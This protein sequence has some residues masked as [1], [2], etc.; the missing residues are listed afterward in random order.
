MRYRRCLRFFCFLVLEPA[1]LFCW[2]GDVK[3]S[4]EIAARVL[5]QNVSND[6]CWV[7]PRARHILAEIHLQSKCQISTMSINTVR[8]PFLVCTTF[9]FVF[10]KVCKGRSQR[11]QKHWSRKQARFV[12]KSTVRDEK[13]KSSKRYVLNNK[14][15][16]FVA[17]NFVPCME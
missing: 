9:N 15:T 16:F 14:S 8:A 2:V 5:F 13:W 11:T 12:T 7:Q 1:S 4:S 6:F 3:R 17:S 10:A